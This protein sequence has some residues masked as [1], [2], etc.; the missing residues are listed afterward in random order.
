ARGSR[1]VGRG[2]AAGL[3][4][5]AHRARMRLPIVLATSLVLLPGA[6][7][8]HTKQPPA[9]ATD[10]LPPSGERAY[11]ALAGRFDRDGAL[12]VVGFM[13]RYWRLAGNPGFDASIDHIRDRL[14]ASGFLA[15]G[16]DGR[17]RAPAAATVRV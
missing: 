6:T 17:A 16:S 3:L 9:S 8:P 11:R 1:D 5:A 7:A 4:G 10:P 15:G 13:D 12:E 2:A 14:V